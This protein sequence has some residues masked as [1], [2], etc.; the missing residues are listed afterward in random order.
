MGQAEE[1]KLPGHI[2]NE[3]SWELVDVGY[4]AVRF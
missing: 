2:I 3:L 1:G 4:N